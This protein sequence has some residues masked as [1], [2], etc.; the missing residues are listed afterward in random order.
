MKTEGRSVSAY[1]PKPMAD[2][3]QQLIDEGKYTS[4]S[5][6]IRT[7]IREKLEAEKQ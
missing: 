3:V 5:D 2:Q 6:F 4:M 7:T 1:I